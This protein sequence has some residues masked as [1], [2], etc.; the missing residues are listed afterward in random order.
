MYVY[1]GAIFYIHI[2][3]YIN[4]CS[5]YVHIRAQLKGCKNLVSTSA[6]CLGS[7]IILNSQKAPQQEKHA[8]THHLNNKE[9]Q[10]REKVIMFSIISIVLKS[11]FHFRYMAENLS[12]LISWSHLETNIITNTRSQ[13][14][15][16]DELIK[17]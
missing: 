11:S 9:K 12:S 1:V 13:C 17:T 7:D 14:S 6:E 3:I 10:G 8:L 5:L 2:Y 15:Q 4:A 16:K